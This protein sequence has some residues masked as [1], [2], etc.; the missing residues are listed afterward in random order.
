[1]HI[2]WIGFTELKQLLQGFIDK[3]DANERS[4]SLFGKPG[5]VADE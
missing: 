2:D 4:K 1:V 5:D 3:N